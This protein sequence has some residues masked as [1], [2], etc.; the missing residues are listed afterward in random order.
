MIRKPAGRPL[1]G[2]LQVPGD[3]SISH[4][5]VMFGSIANGITEAEGFLNSADCRSTIACFR[6]MGIPIDVDPSGTKIRVHGKGLHGLS[7]PDCVLDC[8][9]SGT[10]TRLISG[11][12][13]GQPFR[14]R[15]T[16]DASIRKRPMKRIIDPLS[17]MGAS[18]RSENGTGCA[19]LV[20]EP[21]R[22]HGIEYHSPVASAQVKSCVLLA[23]LYA[24]GPTTVVEPAPSRNH[25]ELMLKGF[26]ARVSTDI[27][28]ATVMPDPDL[29]GIHVNVPGDISSAAYFIAAALLVPGSEVLL[30][31]VGINPTRDGI[32][33]VVRA[34][35]GSVERIEE[36]AS[37]GERS[38]DLLVRSGT[39]HGCRIGGSLIPRLIDEL[40]VIA[41]LAACADGTTV[42]TDAQELRVKESDRLEAIVTSLKSMGADVEGTK[43]GMIIRGGSPLK[44]AVIDSHMDHRIAMAFSVAA[45][46]AD[47]DTTIRD[48]GCV[49]ISYPG[50][51]RDLD[52]LLG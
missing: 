35:G 29:Y 18:I 15:L 27:C 51:Y 43:D 3:K 25:T 34:M 19:P 12:L 23:G 49:D 28:S 10:T 42:I 6:N 4:R 8:G 46:V 7:A 33:E 5:C 36:T 30:P 45:L 22:L 1:K 14:S 38:A 16:G 52:R 48:A 31:G 21:A 13:A 47:G 24:D 39:L 50:F 17:R 41:V 20:I 2:K 9:N 40:P 32:L 11:I 26:G 37:G 44:G